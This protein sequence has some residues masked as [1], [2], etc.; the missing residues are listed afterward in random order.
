MT[1][2]PESRN[3]IR[4]ILA[5]PPDSAEFLAL[6]EALGAAPWVSVDL[7]P[8]LVGACG[9]SPASIKPALYDA[10]ASIR[11]R[12][13][14]E[15]LVSLLD[16]PSVD[17]TLRRAA[18]NALAKQSGRADLGDDPAKWQAFLASVPTEDAWR[19]A[20]LRAFASGLD[21]QREQ[22]SI[23]Q[24]RLLE[25][26]RALHL[27]TPADKR[28][29]LISSM[30]ADPLTCVNLLGL[31]LVSRELSA[32][33]RPDASVGVQILALL[34]SPE[35]AIR[36]QAAIL[37]ANLA[38]EGAEEAIR[39]ALGIERVPATAAALLNAAARWPNAR[40]ELS[41]LRWVDPAVWAQ[42]GALVRDAS[43][44]AAWALY[45][46]GMLRS[47][48]A[49]DRVLDAVRAIKVA[50]LS[51]AGCRLRAELGDRSD[52]EAIVVLLGSKNQ[53]QRLAAAESLVSSPEFL[54]RILA[55]AREDPL[56][57]D[58]AVRGVLTLAPNVSNFAAVEEATRGVPDQRRAALT[59]VAAQLNED[60]VLE[61][62]RLLR[63]DPALREA[64]LATLADPRR[65]MAERTDP[66]R[67]AYT[68]EALV[69]LAELRIELGKFGEAITAID[70][71]PEIQ[72]L[73]PADRLRDL[74]ATALI[75]GN[76]LDQAR[77]LG[78][79]ADVWLRA[80]ELIN[81]QPQAAQVASYIEANLAD[82]LSDADR[83]RLEQLK[84][85]IVSKA[86]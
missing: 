24:S 49:A 31:E 43:L 10:V 23:V 62:S 35:P 21:R 53:S 2:D 15:Y 82:A 3:E 55:A 40:S 19:T 52:L 29:P 48:A 1:D 22:R 9:T 45:R 58:I 32:G 70:A 38:P 85:K 60:E 4:R 14:A 11:E 83:A 33:N 12:A 76:R 61:A 28:W 81:N 37:V 46:A 17:A 41:V 42:S 25:T 80:L 69:E 30:V 78:A 68:A 75:G 56:L 26:L 13:A 84:S 36:E 67:L 7:L 73:A 86:R 77:Q 47:G 66:S 27:A 71:L 16:I 44:D 65:I 18:M 57:L 72:Q 50:D 34:R 39:A 8:D 6:L 59:T 64:V 20:T 74:R 5:L 63:A 51:G 54:P 79:K